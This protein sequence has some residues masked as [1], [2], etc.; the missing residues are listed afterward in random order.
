MPYNYGWL[1]YNS[2]LT[3]T[4]SKVGKVTEKNDS[5]TKGNVNMKRNKSEV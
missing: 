4:G 2:R 1:C 3:I 5:E